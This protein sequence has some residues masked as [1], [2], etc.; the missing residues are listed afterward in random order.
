[1]PV[2]LVLLASGLTILIVGMLPGRPGVRRRALLATALLPACLTA[3]PVAIVGADRIGGALT[4][5]PAW[6]IAAQVTLVAGL[7]AW[8]VGGARRVA[9]PERALRAD[10]EAAVPRAPGTTALRRWRLTT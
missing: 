3:L 5:S 1:D 6:S 4:G 10:P 8:T 7:V 2:V 9:L